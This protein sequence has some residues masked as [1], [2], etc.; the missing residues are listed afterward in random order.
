MT[1]E[2]GVDNYYEVSGADKVDENNL[3]LNSAILLFILSF[4][5]LISA[6]ISSLKLFIIAYR[7]SI[8]TGALV[9]T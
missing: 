2:G 6:L 9:A 7:A 3:D 5:T 8:V 4:M 1:A